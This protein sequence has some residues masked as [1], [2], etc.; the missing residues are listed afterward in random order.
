MTETSSKVETLTLLH[1]AALGVVASWFLGGGSADARIALCILGSLAPLLALAGLLERRARGEPVARPLLPLLAWLGFNAVV[2]LGLM[3]PGLRV[4]AVE[5]I[6]V[7]VP[8][9]VSP[10]LPSS[11]RP[12]LALPELWLLNALVLPAFNLVL[13]VR[14]RGTLRALFSILAINAL[15]LAVFGS[16]QKF[17]GAPGIFFGQV[18]SPNTTFFASFIYHN[19]WGAFV[20]LAVAVCLG[21]LFGLRPWERARDFWHSPAPAAVLAIFLLA[22]TVP[23]SGS[24]ACSM[25]VALLLA[26]GFFH[27]L[28]RIVAH[29]REHGRSTLLPGALLVLVALV[30]VAATVFLAREVVETRIADTRSQLANLKGTGG[31]GARGTLYADTWHMFADKPWFGHGLASYPTVFRSYNTQ[32]GS[33]GLPHFYEYA[34]SDWLQLL[35]ETGIAGTTFVL[36]F[37]LSLLIP[38]LARRRPADELP[39]CLLAGCGLVALYACIEF[40]FGNPAVALFFWTCLLGS[41]RWL[42]LGRS[43]SSTR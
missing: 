42:R 19:H 13:N 32:V 21:L 27:G 9:E 39:V 26:A 16:L 23:L 10:L 18:R 3:H 6:T 43:A 20:V 11:A 24:R 35:A 4:A 22:L 33:E 25:L 12:D 34:H 5:G 36:A 1:V 30:A 38:A 14:H 31:I 7:F 8:V 28:R 2:L 29:H 15:V 37:A 41:V 17:V 40:P